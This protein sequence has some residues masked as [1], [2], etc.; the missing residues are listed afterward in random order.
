MSFTQ[1]RKLGITHAY[2]RTEYTT[3]Y[4][5]SKY[6]KHEYFAE[7]MSHLKCFKEVVGLLSGMYQKKGEAVSLVVRSLG[8]KTS[9][10][11]SWDCRFHV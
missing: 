3:P 9:S 7:C 8:T 1:W 11:S 5:R 10:Q 6:V 4:V 2:Q